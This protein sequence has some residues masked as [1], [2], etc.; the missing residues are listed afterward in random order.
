ML[1]VTILCIITLICFN[2]GFS[3][4][5][6]FA[7]VTNIEKIN[8]NTIEFDIYIKG[9]TAPLELSSY[10]CVFTF[11]KDISTSQ[12]LSF[13]YIPGSSQLKNIEPEVGIGINNSDGVAKLTFASM[14]GNELITSTSTKIGRFNLTTDGSFNDLPLNL[15]WCFDGKIN[16]ILTGANFEDITDSTNHADGNIDQ[17]KVFNVV[18]SS[19]SD[20]TTDALKT[21][22]GKGS[23][24]GDPASRW[25]TQ[26]MPAYLIFDLGAAKHISKTKFSFYYWD[27]NRVYKYSILT[28]KDLYNWDEVISN[29]S[30]SSVEWTSNNIN[31]DA[32][33]VKLIFLSSNQNDWANLWEAQ[34]YG[35]PDTTEIAPPAEKANPL[36]N[37]P[38]RIGDGIGDSDTLFVGIDSAACNGLDACLGEEQFQVP[39]AGTFSAWLNMPNSQIATRK[40]YR[41]GLQCENYEYEYQIQYQKG[42]ANKINLHWSVPSAVKLRVQD[43]ITGEIIDTIFNSGEDSLII[44]DPN[45]VYKLNLTVTYLSKVLPVELTSFNGNVV[46]NSVELKWKTATEINNKGFEIERKIPAQD[47]WQRIGF[48]SGNGT[49]TNPA[50]YKFTDDLKSLMIS[51]N[52]SYRLKQVN[53]NGSSAYSDEINVKVDLTPKSFVLYQNYPN[54]FNPSTNIQYALPFESNV[55][56]TIYNSLG[57]RIKEFAQGVKDAGNHDI[58][59][60]ANNQASGVYFYT[61]TAKSTDGKNSFNKTQKMMLLK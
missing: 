34:I 52:I 17:L 39:A 3:N 45:D 30:S 8:S 51:G 26:P 23:N 44:N 57:E 14:P 56:I 10:Q 31:I 29:D 20:T 41:Y 58:I 37:I 60:Y 46:N 50:Q 11:N 9:Q 27:Q 42:S 24:D 2:T 35:N 7:E 40:D 47:Q 43:I 16:T 49:S 38:I 4:S 53:Y 55:N 48:V 32:R 1:K 18:A 59:W 19:T 36:V 13:T 6:Y 33:Y 15:K 12:N 25:A 28:S 61:I 22:D 5:N 21:I 54:P